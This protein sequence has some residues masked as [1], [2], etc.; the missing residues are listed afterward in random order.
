MDFI[1]NLHNRFTQLAT[2]YQSKIEAATNIHGRIAYCDQDIFTIEPFYAEINNLPLH[3]VQLVD[4]PEQLQGSQIFQVLIS[5]GK[6]RLHREWM[7]E[8]CYY[9]GLFEYQDNQKTRL[10]VFVK[11]NEVKP[12]RLEVINYDDNGYYKD[13]YAVSQY[14]IE[15]LHYQYLGLT[16]RIDRFRIDDDFQQE[17]IYSYQVYR[18]EQDYSIQKIEMVHQGKTSIIYNANL[19][20]QSLDDLLK[21]ALKYK[22]RDILEACKQ[23]ELQGK[24]IQC[25]LI[26]YSSQSPMNSSLALIQTSEVDYKNDYPLAWLNAPDA[27]LF[28]EE[29]ETEYQSVYERIDGLFDQMQDQEYQTNT[30][31]V[32][33]S[34]ELESDET[35]TDQIQNSTESQRLMKEFYIKLCKSLKLKLRQQATFTLD[36][37]FFVCA[38]DYEACNEEEYLQAILPVKQYKQICKIIDRQKVRQK[39][40]LANNPIRLLADSIKQ[41]AEQL[42]PQLLQLAETSPTDYW[43]S[44][45]RYYF[46]EPFGFELKTGKTGRWQN[47]LTR[48]IPA[49]SFYFRYQLIDDLPISIAQISEGKIVR[50]WFWQ[51]TSDRELEIE[52][53][54][55]KNKPFVESC[56]LLELKDGRVTSYSEFCL[57]YERTDYQWDDSGKIVQSHFHRS[58]PD[59]PDVESGMDFF[60]EYQDG[61]ISKIYRQPTQWDNDERFCIFFP[62]QNFDNIK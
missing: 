35:D 21:Q 44:K 17:F 25:L 16:T 56:N 49:S 39:Q 59:H 53:Y 42:L 51:R 14:G 32:L 15:E 34:A 24:H 28:L 58:F 62:Q 57:S 19:N 7:G 23:D 8:N 2:E 10:L 9:D 36:D 61:K 45:E 48:K 3:Q 18:S 60:Y 50:Q 33:V 4:D 37:N 1:K 27:E 52:Y 55:F 46:I 6:A 11:D 5:E 30:H 13:F 22:T 40:R 54:C 43:Y 38:R 20:Q 12:I 26:E 31:D 47:F 29:P 41:E